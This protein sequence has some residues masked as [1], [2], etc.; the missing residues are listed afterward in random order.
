[1]SF[2]LSDGSI[3]G[4]WRVS[5]PY[6]V[7]NLHQMNELDKMNKEASNRT[8]KLVEEAVIRNRENQH[9]REAII[10]AGTA[11]NMPNPS[12]APA[13]PSLGLPFP[14][15]MP[16]RR[17]YMAGLGRFLTEARLAERL[18]GEHPYA[19]AFNNPT[20]YID[21]EGLYAIK[22][23]DCKGCGKSLLI[24]PSP[25]DATGIVVGP[26]KGKPGNTSLLSGKD[27]VALAK[28]LYPGKQCTCVNG[29]FFSGSNPMGSLDPCNSGP[30]KGVGS[31]APPGSGREEVIITVG[32][33]HVTGIIGT[34][35]SPGGKNLP[36]RTGACIDKRGRLVAIVVTAGCSASNF[37]RCARSA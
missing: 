12:G 9:R 29:G 3:V 14:A 24:T 4:P 30:V 26:P 16:G 17:P 23:I 27:C 19:Y 20:T 35:P 5:T 2:E 36:G 13:I 31:P 18:A 37:E 25:G 32:G 34:P 11:R 28:K 1:M 7:W 33:D 22:P 8:S 15:Q 10:S 6:T 21:P